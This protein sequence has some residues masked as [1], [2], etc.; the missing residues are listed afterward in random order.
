M[1]HQLNVNRLLDSIWYKNKIWSYFLIPFSVIY[2]CVHNN[3][4][5]YAK[6]KPKKFNV[7]VIVV[8]NLTVGGT[9]KTPLVIAIVNKLT[10]D[11]Y[12][13][14]I[15]SRGYKSTVKKYPYFVTQAD[16]P[17]KVGD[18]P[19]LVARRTNCAVVIAPERNQAID[20]LIQKNN[21]DII[22]SDDG[23]QHYK[24]QRHLEIVLIDG[25]RGFGNG[26][27]LPAGPLRETKKRLQTVD[28][29]VVNGDEQFNLS[30]KNIFNAIV[31]PQKITGLI[32]ESTFNKNTILE[33]VTGIGN[34]DR[35]FNTLTNLQIQFKP[36]VFPDHYKFTQQDFSDHKP[37]IMTE[38][39][40]VKCQK[41]AKDNMYY[42][43]IELNL[44]KEFWHIFDGYIRKIMQGKI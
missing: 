9:G 41:F 11:G 27:L 31:E 10:Q 20:Y 33:A 16:D 2:Y 19:L 23:L 43:P 7:P 21:P 25:K 28:M 1:G 42:L 4:K 39:D 34:P 3:L 40:A 26:L 29:I 38:K 5:F 17:D 30:N 32:A 15:V 22:V 8:G 14:G 6:L 35:F 24:M 13:V 12:K 36:K 37:I 44:P 18:E